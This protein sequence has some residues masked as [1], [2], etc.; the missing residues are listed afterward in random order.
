V[1]RSPF[2]HR[3]KTRHATCQGIACRKQYIDQMT[4]ILS[5]RPFMVREGFWGVDELDKEPLYLSRNISELRSRKNL[6]QQQLAQMAGSHA[7]R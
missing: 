5:K 2:M 3:R 7:Q 1:T 4:L 6:S